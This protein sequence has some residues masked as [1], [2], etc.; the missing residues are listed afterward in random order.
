MG[1]ANVYLPDDLE[2]RVK[3]ARIPVSEVCQQALLA[4]VEAAEADRPRFDAALGDLFGRGGE[5]GERWARAAS[6]ATLLAL[7]RDQRLGQIPSDQLPE[8]WYSLNEE[9]TTAWEAGFVEAARAVARAAV[10][11]LTGPAAAGGVEGGAEGAVTASPDPTDLPGEQAGLADAAPPA[12]EPPPALGDGSTS[13]IGVDHAG[14][15][16]AF[17]PHTAVADDKSPLFAVLG[18]AD[19][20]A[21]LALSIGQDAASRGVAVVMLDLSG[22]LTPRAHGLGK[23]VRVPTSAQQ[24]LPS[25]DTLL[26]SAG[27]MRGLWDLLGGLS[28]AGGSLFPGFGASSPEL[29]T[30]GYVTVLTVSGDGPLGGVAGA[31]NGLKALAELTTKAAHPQLLLV[32]LPA[33]VAVPSQLAA[34]LSRFVRTARQN[35]VAVGLSAES[36]DAVADVGG[37]GALLSTVFAFPTSSPVEADRLRDLLG[38]QAPI[39]LNPPGFAPRGEDDVWC[40]MRD[41]AGRLG[42]V[43]LDA[44]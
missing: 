13:Y 43:R 17:D 10:N 27:G 3:A 33:G 40:T 31:M 44:A 26:G 37:A 30:P 1:R 18:P 39:L 29:V 19:Q 32:D 12:E 25:I 23:T 14:R 28:T 22:Q 9:L 2:R 5:A 11:D 15:R 7:V 16:I 21:H 4:A 8:F 38:A 6:P 35:N 34:A 42:Q 36:A 24:P 20:R 41:L